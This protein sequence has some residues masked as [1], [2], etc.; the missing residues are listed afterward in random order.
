MSIKNSV[1]NSFNS[2][3]DFCES[4]N[5][6]G[7]DPYDGLNSKLFNAMPNFISKNKWAR[8]SITQ[9][10]KHSPIN[11]RKILLVEKGHNPKGL[12][13]FL[14][15][16]CNMF[17]INNDHELLVKINFLAD[18][19][20]ELKTKGFSGACWGYNFPWQSRAFY[21]EKFSPT[22]VASSF[23]GYSLMDAYEIT[24]KEEYLNTAI[25]IKDFVLN[26]LNKKNYGDN[27]LIFSYSPFDNTEVINAS[28]LGA[29]LLSR[30]YSYTKEE[31]LINYAKKSVSYACKLQSKDGAWPYGALSYQNWIDSFHTGY[32][33][34]A[35]NE[36]RKYSN[37]NSFDKNIDLG[38]DYYLNNF[39]QEDG[40]P[41]Y[42]NDRVYP[43]D[44]HC[45]A[46]FL[47]TISEFGIKNELV[48]KMLLWTIYNMQN[49]EKGYFFF[50]KKKYWTSKIPYMRWS[51][52]WM[53]YA[54]SKYIKMNNF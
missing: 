2:L 17:L 54:M 20:L 11:F 34:E 5:Y 18:K 36:Y 37:D 30:I 8:I 48:D 39:I 21:Q 25:S 13:L 49:K 23:I 33:L 14:I 10:L 22:V 51:Q 50:Q 4:E 24:K 3:K 27:D 15:G 16:Y 31:E 52:A 1:E 9:F 45:P 53:F 12:S 7:W 29:K 26:D 40:T 35:I 44:V 38:L 32:N 47:S 41:K 19:L 43:I 46:Q 28:L 6:S 42:Y